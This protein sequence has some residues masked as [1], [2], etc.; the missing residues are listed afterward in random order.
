MASHPEA[1]R[2][3]HLVMGVDHEHK[4]YLAT[5]LLR[6]LEKFWETGY[7]FALAAMEQ[8]MVHKLVLQKVPYEN[9]CASRETYYCDQNYKQEAL[10]LYSSQAL[11]QA[12]V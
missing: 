11:V 3:I 8:Y 10:L 12:Q 4:P 9:A 5:D 6:E 2:D 1:L 7:L